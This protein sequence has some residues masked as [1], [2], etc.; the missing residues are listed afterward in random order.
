LQ[1]ANDNNL[2]FFTGALFQSPKMLIRSPAGVIASITS[3]T[4][5]ELQ[6]IAKQN[7]SLFRQLFGIGKEGAQTML[8]QH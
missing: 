5:A 7:S 8:K 2:R 3:K 4:T 1:E 6:V